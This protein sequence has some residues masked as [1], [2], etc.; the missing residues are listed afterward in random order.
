MHV[1]LVL[2][3]LGLTSSTIYTALS[4]WVALRFAKRRPTPL[5][6]EF[7]PPVSLLK[8]LHGSEPRPAGVSA[9]EC[10]LVGN[11]VLWREGVY[12]LLRGGL[13]RKRSLSAARVGWGE[14]GV[15]VPF[16]CR[17]RDPGDLPVS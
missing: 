14:R 8:P 5:A 16:L 1:L 12:E 15:P 2:G 13:M 9:L 6:S 10:K 3:L 17:S 11:K 4:V 7:R